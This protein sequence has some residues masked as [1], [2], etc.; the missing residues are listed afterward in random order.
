MK[1]IGKLTKNR[2][3][4]KLKYIIMGLFNFNMPK[5]KQFNYR[6]L[7]YDER[8]ER[9]EKMKARA[10]IEN[11]RG[12][13]NL[14]KGFL[15]ESRAKSKMPRIE[16]PKASTWR[17]VRFLIILI[18]LIGMSYMLVPEAFVTFWNTK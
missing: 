14:E 4:C 6:P 7:Y 2:F 16:I 3:L 15:T 8:K 11:E 9:L 12:Y 18:V 17:L 13:T 1:K 10:K 5:P